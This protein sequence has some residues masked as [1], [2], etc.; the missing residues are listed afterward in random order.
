MGLSVGPV[1]AGPIGSEEQFE[2][3]VIG[4]SVNLAARLQSLTRNIEG[5]SIIL[6]TDVYDALN[7]MVKD[8]IRITTLEQYEQLNE[9][10]KARQPVQCVDLGLVSVKGKQG[11]VHV[12]GIPDVDTTIPG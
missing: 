2:Y 12:Y 9:R 1:V 8:Q 3:T 4:D 11:P 10:E 5:F 7:T 6:T